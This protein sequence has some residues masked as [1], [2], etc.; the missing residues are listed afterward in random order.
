MT[1]NAGTQDSLFIAF[2][3]G[4]PDGDLV[5]P[6]SWVRIDNVTMHNGGATITNI[7]DPSFENWT[8]QVVENPDDWFTINDVLSS[9]GIANVIK[10]IDANSGSFSV[11]MTTTV[12]PNGGDTIASFLSNGAIDLFGAIPFT[13][14][15][16]NASPTTFSGAYKYA[17][18]NADQGFI[19]IQFFEAGVVVG[20]HV[21]PFV[22]QASWVTFN[23]PIIITSTP[24]SMLFIAYSGDNAGSVLKLDDLALSGGDVGLNEFASMNISMYPNPASSSVMIKAEGTYNYS[25]SDLA[26]NVIMTESNVNGAIQ[27][28]IN[29]LSSGAYFVTINNAVSAETHKLIVE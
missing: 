19:Q 17:G 3:L 7:P 16:Y 2:I 18:V 13:N 9:F 15:P 23:S 6:A 8:D 14:A 24:D 28:D 21:E 22:N 4:N 25:I 11:E 5:D 27:L 20:T 10:S 26:G 12:L 1:V 29:N